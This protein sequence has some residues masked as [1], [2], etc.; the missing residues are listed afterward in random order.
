MTLKTQPLSHRLKSLWTGLWRLFR[1]TPAPTLAP[2]PESDQDDDEPPFSPDQPL[3]I[4]IE[5]ELDLHTFR[6][7]EIVDVVDAYLTE[8]AERGFL[9]VRVIHGKGKGVQRRRVQSLLT[10]HPHVL[11]FADAP[12][13]RGGWGAT[14]VW[15]KPLPPSPASSRD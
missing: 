2:A 6:P 13:E 8:A 12:P 14:L 10:R 3:V 15:L 5:H 4:P 7:D 1:P 9:E 11:R